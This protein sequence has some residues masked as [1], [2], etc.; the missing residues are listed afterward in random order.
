MSA[1]GRDKGGSPSE[2]IGGPARRKPR[3]PARLAVIMAAVAHEA[4]IF[5]RGPAEWFQVIRWDT[6]HDRFH[7]GAWIR[8]RIYPEKCDLSPDGRLLVYSVHKA[9]GLR[10]AYT[11]C[12]TGISRSP[13][14]AA[15]ALWPTGTTYGG[16]GRFD[17]DRRV[18]LRVCAA[19]GHHPDHPPCGLAVR[20]GAPPMH[21]V[22]RVP[23]VDWQGHDQRGRTFHAARGKLLLGT[24][25]KP[26]RVLADF[27]GRLPDPVA[28][29][30]WARRPLTNDRR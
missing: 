10:T 13:W 16:G 4:V 22:S 21:E 17:A 20:C 28:A 12:W 3:P 25:A 30:A 9:A 24:A 8:G 6:R 5:R 1:P 27:N 14:L 19:D 29:P 26:G 11:D 15:L 7:D 2:A 18:T 23:G